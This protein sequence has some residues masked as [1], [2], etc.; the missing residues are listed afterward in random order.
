MGGQDNSHAKADGIRR[1]G[2]GIEA[3][4]AAEV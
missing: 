2:A 4:R 3:L 1:D